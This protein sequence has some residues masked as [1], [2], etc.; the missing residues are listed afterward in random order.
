MPQ[1]TLCVGCCRVRVT[2][3]RCDT[4]AAAYGVQKAGDAETYGRPW[5]RVRDAFLRRFPLCGMRADGQSHA[6]HSVCVQQRRVTAAQQVDHIKPKRYGGTDGAAN[7]QSLCITCH[8][9]KRRLEERDRSRPSPGGGKGF[10][11]RERT[12]PGP[13]TQKI[14]ISKVP[15][16]QI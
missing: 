11:Q 9:A 15:Q 2:Q 4:C 8:A 13:L 3:G 16:I 10:Q 12:R 14:A 5:R 7:L 1:M 6:V